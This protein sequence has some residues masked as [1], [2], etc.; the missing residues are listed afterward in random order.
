[1]LGTSFFPS[2]I[3]HSIDATG[4]TQIK[5]VE[6]EAMGLDVLTVHWHLIYLCTVILLNISQYA[7]IITLDKVDGDTLAAVTT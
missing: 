5:R 4:I 2:Y 6:F 3:Y 7:D 1:M